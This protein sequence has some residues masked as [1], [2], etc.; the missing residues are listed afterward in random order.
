M[1]VLLDDDAWIAWLALIVAAVVAEM[2]RLDLVG[3][4]GGVAALT[5]LLVGLVGAPWWLQALVAVVAAAAL[6]GAA[7]PAL[8]RALPVEG[9]VADDDGS[10]DPP[11]AHDDRVPPA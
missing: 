5:G 4:C 11:P 7:R 8:L 2:R 6:L 3:L 10:L 1:T 9:E